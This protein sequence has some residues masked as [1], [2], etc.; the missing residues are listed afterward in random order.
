MPI[1]KACVS[2]LRMPTSQQIM[3]SMIFILYSSTSSYKI[4]VTQS[5]ISTTGQGFFS[6]Y[7]ANVM[8][9]SC[10]DCLLVVLIKEATSIYLLYLWN[11]KSKK[12]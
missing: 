8:E 1:S 11:E 10:Q 6:F 2:F 4:Q 5:V 12:N 9:E 3:K 7:P